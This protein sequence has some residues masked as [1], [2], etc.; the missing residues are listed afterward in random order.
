MDKKDLNHI[1]KEKIKEVEHKIIP[2]VQW[3][4]EE[5]WNKIKEILSSKNKQLIMWYFATAASV[6]VLVAATLDNTLPVL[7]QFLPKTETVSIAHQPGTISPVSIPPIANTRKEIALDPLQIK[8]PAD[9]SKEIVTDPYMFKHI[10]TVADRQS[11]TQPK[12]KD[13]SIPS[14]KINVHTSTNSAT[15]ITPGI[16]L[17]YQH[18]LKS[19]SQ[20]TKYISIGTYTN[21]ILSPGN[22]SDNNGF[23]PATFINAA[24]GQKKHQKS[25]AEWEIGAGY[26]LNPN[27]VIYKDTTLRF[28]YTRTIMGRLK[29]GPELI[30]TNSLT[31]VYP[32]ITL[33]FG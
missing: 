2:G 28:H 31:K 8:E 1:V 25:N 6:S 14:I 32:G 12:K 16:S 20:Q 11:I 19:N 21:F 33:A 22:E 9:Y 7:E 15:N 4:K 3:N 26:L 17:Q 18:V 30:L 5:S 24:Y 23:Y 29:V 27:Q 13:K 10:P